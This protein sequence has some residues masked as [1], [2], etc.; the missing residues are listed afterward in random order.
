MLPLNSYNLQTFLTYRKQ[1][2]VAKKWEENNYLRTVRN[3]TVIS[4]LDSNIATKKKATVITLIRF[5]TTKRYI[6]VL[7][8]N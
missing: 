2:N 7:K 5:Q 3:F 6:R 8:K 1:R 4:C